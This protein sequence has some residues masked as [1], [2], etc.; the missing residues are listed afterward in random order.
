MMKGCIKNAVLIAL[1]L[2]CGIAKASAVSVSSLAELASYAG[3]SGNVIT[4]KPG[5]YQ[6][7]DY[8]TMDS[9]RVRH[10]RKQFQYITFSGSNNTFNLEGVEIAV[11]TELRT[12]LNPPIH[13]DEFL[14]TGNDNTFNGL[15]IRCVGN[16]T[17]PGGTVLQVAGTGNVLKDMTLYVA[18]SYPYGYGD[19][20]GKGGETVIK[21][22]KHSGLLVTGSNTRL[23]R[24]KLYNR[25]FGHCFFV[26][27]GAENVYFEDC[28]AEGAVRSTDE[29]LAETSGPA[30]D[31]NFRTWTQNREG[32]YVVTPGYMKSLSED[33]FRTYGEIKNIHFKNCTAKNTRAG[34]ELRTNGGTRLE[35]CTTIGT[36]R[37]YWVGD[38][39]IVKNCKGDANYGPL[40]FVEGSNADVELV[41]DTAESD[42]LV[43]ALVTIQGNNNKVVLKSEKGYKRKTDLPILVGYTH[44]EHGESM[45]PYSEGKTSGLKLT[46]E[47]GMPVKISAL[48]SNSKIITDGKVLENNG[49]NNKIIKKVRTSL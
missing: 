5:V 30:V 23:Y 48:V 17:S 39:A 19:L 3:K 43:H 21:H 1:I 25:S 2:V 8:L 4:M 41:V 14:V 28:Y 7:T 33:G 44:P 46:N 10:D 49:K 35:N 11:D 29:I 40:M 9:M 16:G 24:C 32:K 12:A 22:K 13:S 47:T 38:G 26:Q 37:G 27:K 20:F 18:G 15:T 6:L 42:R 34:F 45:S 31:V 36:E